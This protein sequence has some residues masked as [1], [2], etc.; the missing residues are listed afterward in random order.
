ME[1]EPQTGLER[2]IWH[3]LRI[4]VRTYEAIGI[5]SAPQGAVLVDLAGGAATLHSVHAALGDQL[6][7]SC[8][9]GWSRS[10]ARSSSIE[11][12]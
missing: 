1:H 9:V 5:L 12:L 4:A 10:Q 6:K 7:Y 2:F 8:R 11:M 3:K